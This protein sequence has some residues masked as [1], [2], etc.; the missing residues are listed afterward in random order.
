MPLRTISIPKPGESDIERFWSKVDKSQG[1]GPGG[2]CW[3]WTAHLNKLGYGQF[4]MG[5]RD[6]GNQYMAHR[7]AYVISIGD[8]PKWIFVL[9]TCDNPSCVNPTH[10]WLGTALDNARDRDEKGRGSRGDEHYSRVRPELLARGLRNGR[11][12]KPERT[13]RGSRHGSHTKPESVGRGAANGR[14]ILTEAQVLEIRKRHAGGGHFCKDL[15]V[16][17]GVGKAAVERIVSRRSWK[18]I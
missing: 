18:H 1:Q 2:D 5:C 8:I 10:L 4:W 11:H 15:A 3:V 13:A 9:H 7:V 16:E 17:Y 12:T 14:A 6:S